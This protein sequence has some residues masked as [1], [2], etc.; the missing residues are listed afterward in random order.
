MLGNVR[1]NAV[2]TALIYG[3]VHVHS[4]TVFN[5]IIICLMQCSKWTVRRKEGLQVGL[6]SWNPGGLRL[7]IITCYCINTVLIHLPKRPSLGGRGHLHLTFSNIYIP[8]LAQGLG[9][10]GGVC[11]DISLYYIYY[12]SVQE[13]HWPRQYTNQVCSNQ[14]PLSIIHNKTSL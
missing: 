7:R 8:G 12:G 1:F 10:G 6:L 3:L 11:A 14:L 5:Y 9:G 4:D 13:I 2:C